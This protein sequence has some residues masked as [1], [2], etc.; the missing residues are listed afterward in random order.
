MNFAF[1][2]VMVEKAF[3]F[4]VFLQILLLYGGEKYELLSYLSRP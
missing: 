3:A 2:A 1:S 4:F